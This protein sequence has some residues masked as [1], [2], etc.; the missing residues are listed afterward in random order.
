LA[1][2]GLA[3]FYLEGVTRLLASQP[4]GKS[5]EAKGRNTEKFAGGAG[6]NFSRVVP[7]R[8]RRVSS[9]II[10]LF[11]FSNEKEKES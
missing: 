11:L 8:S 10:F 4:G 1:W 2:L 6:A 3:F 7:R 5:R 9:F